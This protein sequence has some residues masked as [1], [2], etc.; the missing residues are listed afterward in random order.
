MALMRQ[1]PKELRALA[2][3]LNFANKKE[4]DAQVTCNG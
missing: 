3:K 1:T 4:G 2:G